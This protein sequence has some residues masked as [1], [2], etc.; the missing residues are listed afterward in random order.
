MI[1][2]NLSGVGDQ[3]ALAH[4]LLHAGRR[5]CRGRRLRGARPRR[6]PDLHHQDD[7]G[8][9]RLARRDDGGD[10]EP[11]HRPAR[12]PAAG[13]DRAGFGAV[14]HPAGRGDDLCRSGR[15]LPAR[16]R[17]RRLA[18]GPQQHGRHPPHLAAGRARTVLQRRLRRC[19]R[20]RL[21]A[22]RRTASPIANCATMSRM[23]ARR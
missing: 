7:A 15:H 19:L 23:C 1:G 5:H 2:P 8:D 20:D 16:R 10:A 6:R 14:D 22:S 12:A 21:R 9:R 18:G 17:R 13:D 4:P 11:A 3:C